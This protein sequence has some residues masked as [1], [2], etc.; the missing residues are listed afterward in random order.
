MVVCAVPT[1]QAARPDGTLEVTV[2]TA[3]SGDPVAARVQLSRSGGRPLRSR[4]LGVAPLGDHFYVDGQTELGLRR[5][6]Y[7]FE[8]TA[9]PEYKP[10]TGRFEIERRASDS[11]RVEMH[12]VVRL[13]EEGWA[14]ADLLA[15]RGGQ[16]LDAALR[17]EGLRYTPLTRWRWDGGNWDEVPSAESAPDAPVTFGPWAARARTEL[18]DLLL[19]NPEEPITREQLEPVS[20]GG[21][22]ALADLR[23][24]GVRIVAADAASWRLPVWLAADVLDAVVVIDP[25]DQSTGRKARSWGR[26][27]DRD[28]YSG[29]R[30][31]ALWRESIYFHILSAGLPIPPAAGSNTGDNELPLGSC[32]VYARRFD[33]FSRQG[34]WDALADGQAMVTNGP[35]LRPI[36]APGER[37]RLMDDNTEVTLGLNLTTRSKVDYLEVVKNGQVEHSVSLRELADARGELPA[38]DCSGSGWFVLRAIA[39]DSPGYERGMTAPYYYQPLHGEPR[40]SRASCEFFLAWL[41]EAEDRLPADEIAAAQR[42]W[43][44]RLAAANAP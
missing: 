16:H 26:P 32:R 37:Y 21:A 6:N 34:W 38:I 27:P 11:K 13:N 40:V 10:I 30:G 39:M 29:A 41:R 18:G 44:R 5:G 3:D 22:D 9:G 35:L 17:G 43:R 25:S 4:G 2:V 36:P 33:G 12:R 1:V 15:A 19:V 28:F 24:R 8:L 23:E 7:E 31:P 42:F 20:D 14:G